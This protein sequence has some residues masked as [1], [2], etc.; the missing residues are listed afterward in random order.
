VCGTRR[1]LLKQ[2]AVCCTPGAKPP[3][4]QKTETDVTR[5]LLC[6]ASRGAVRC[7]RTG[8][9]V[10]TVVQATLLKHAQ[11]LQQLGEQ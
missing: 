10:E 11:R 5:V 3:C 6:P 4:S 2:L 9:A 7:Q 8:T 1:N